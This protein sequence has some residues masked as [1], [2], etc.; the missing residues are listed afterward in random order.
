MVNSGFHGWQ[1]AEQ[2]AIG[3]EDIDKAVTRTRHVIVFVWLFLERIGHKEVAVDVWI[4]KGAN[5]AGMSGSEK[6]PGIWVL[7]AAGNIPPLGAL[8]AKTSIFAL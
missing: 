2:I 1:N 7:S 5:P 8:G 3:I 4:P 6:L